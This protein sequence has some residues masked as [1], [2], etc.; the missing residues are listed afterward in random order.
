MDATYNNAFNNGGANPGSRLTKSIGN[1]IYNGLQVNIQQRLSHGIQIQGAYTFSHAIDNVNDPLV[2]GGGYAPDYNFPHNT[3]DLAAERGNSDFDIR[4]RG[5]VNFIYEPDFGRGR[6][7]LN[8]GFVGRVLEG[9]S[10][11]GIIQAQTGHPFDILGT[12]DSNH[13]GIPARGYLISP[14][15]GQPPGTDKTF[16]GP[17]ASAIENT[18]FDVQPNTGKNMFYGPHLVTRLAALKN[19]TSNREDHAAIPARNVQPIQPHAIQSAGQSD[20]GHRHARESGDVRAITLHNHT[21][22]RNHQRAAAAVRPETDFLTW[23]ELSNKEKRHL[24]RS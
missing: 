9:W 21:A 11:T 4:H 3:F 19:T 1:S 7:H 14:F 18:P 6:G 8:S 17:A 22:G 12:T 24:T 2:A 15:W 16:T 20:S 5:V 13:T 10:L 23:R